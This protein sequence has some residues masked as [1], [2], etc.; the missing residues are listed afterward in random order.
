VNGTN[1]M[2]RG[3]RHRHGR[4]VLVGILN[5]SFLA[6]ASLAYGANRWIGA[7]GFFRNHFDDLLAGFMLLSWSN[8]IALNSRSERAVSSVG[9]A[10]AIIIFASIVW[11]LVIPRVLSNRT[12]DAVDVLAY[13]AGAFIYIAALKFVRRARRHP[14]PRHMLKK[15]A[16]LRQVAP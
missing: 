11:E 16:K 15:V 4:A 13:F 7:G 14:R 1:W 8:L 9:G 3:P 2:R 12:A 10:I 6:V 5:L